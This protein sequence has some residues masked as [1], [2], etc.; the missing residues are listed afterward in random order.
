MKLVVFPDPILSQRC[1]DIVI[2]AST[3]QLVDAMAESMYAE[4]GVGLAAPQ[5]GLAKRLVLVDP[6]AG[7]SAHELVAMANPTIV[8]TSRELEAAEE[9]CL[10]LPGVRLAIARPIA[11]DVEY[12]DMSGTLRSLRCTG[13]KA[14]IVQHE[15]D[16]LSGTMMLDKVGSLARRF[17]LRNVRSET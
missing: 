1:D 7:D 8:W 6:S 2:D 15:V 3:K 17:A 13:W 4:S 9:G 5:V 10:S 14:R 12:I 16:H 11:C